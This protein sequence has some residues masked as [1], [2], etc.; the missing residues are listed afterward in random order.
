MI[1]TGES[2][3]AKVGE[4]KSGLLAHAEKV[5][6]KGNGAHDA[7]EVE[8]HSKPRASLL[9]RASVIAKKSSETGEKKASASQ[10]TSTQGVDVSCSHKVS[11]SGFVPLLQ[12]KRRGTNQA[13]IRQ[14]D[15]GLFS[16]SNDFK[17]PAV[18]E[19]DSFKNL[20][21]SVLYN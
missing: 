13:V 11:Q 1:S 17:V 16:I 3:R 10:E 18:A 5:R 4:K 8:I 21:D 15:D 14:D 6:S 9:L 7:G 12:R 20:V 19:N 2:A